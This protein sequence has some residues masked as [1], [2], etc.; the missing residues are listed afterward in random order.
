MK[1]W[2][3]GEAEYSPCRRYRYTLTRTMAPDL[4]GDDARTIAFIGLNPSTATAT[5]DDPT[6][7]RCIGYAAREGFGRFVML[8]A[9]GFRAT[10]PNDMKAQADPVGDGND[11]A[12]AR[13]ASQADLV[14]LAWGAHG[15]HWGRHDAVLDLLDGLCDPVCLGVTKAG[16]PRHPLYLRSDAA[17]VPFDCGCAAKG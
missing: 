14:V 11:A 13:V 15:T 1:L 7:R 4:V 17:F 5:T 10:D 2:T 9:F 8:N 16:L 6:V 3:R 12:I